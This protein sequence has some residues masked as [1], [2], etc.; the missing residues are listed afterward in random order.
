[1]YI[2]GKGMDEISFWF[3]ALVCID[4]PFVVCAILS[5]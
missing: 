3:N 5:L 2:E 4:L 1:M